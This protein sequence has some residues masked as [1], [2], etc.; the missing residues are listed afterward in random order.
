MLDKAMRLCEAPFG[1]MRHFDGEVFRAMAARDASGA[2]A[3]LGRQA[4]PIA[5]DPGSASERLVLGDKVVHIPDVVDTEAYRSGVPSRLRFVEMT[6][7]RTALWVALRKNDV[8]LGDLALYRKEVR[9]FT[10]KQIAL[11]ENFAAQAVIAM[12]N[13]RLLTET[14]EALEQQT[15]TA[16]VLQV[17][18]SSPGDR[19]PVF[20]VILEKARILCGAAQGSLSLYD[21]ERFRAVAIISQS[22]DVVD[23]M[24]QG[25]LPSDYPWLKPLLD[26]ARLVHV[27]DLVELG[28]PFGARTGLFVPLRKDGAL[29]GLISAIRLEVRPFSDKEIA[30]LENFAAQAVIAMENARLLTET[31][32]ALEQQTA[33]AEVLQVINSSPG[34]LAP[35]FDAMLEKAMRLCETPFG[36]FLRYDGG[37]YSLAAAK[38]LFPEFLNYLAHMDQPV[39]GDSNA[40]VLEGE[41]YVHVVDLKDTDTYRSGSPLRRANVDLGGFRSGLTVPLRKDDR[42]LGTFCIGRQEVRPFSEK[43]IALARNFAAQAVIAMENARLLGEL[44]QRTEEVAELNRGLEAH[45]AEQVDELGRIGRLKRFLAP[46]LAELIV[47]HG[48]EKILES[49]RR[50][51]VVVFCDLRG[52]TAFTETAEPEEVLDF[53]REYHGALGPLVSQF[54]GHARPVLRRRDHGVLQRSGALPRPCRARGQDGDG[55]ARRGG[56][57][58][59]HVATARARTRLW[60]WHRA[61]L[62]DPRADRLCR[63]VGLHRNWHR[64]QCRRPAVCRGQG[65]TDI[66]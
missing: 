56:Q 49:H 8:L 59:C 2:V 24:R 45:V 62:C 66:A 9:P 30:L 64:L 42:V 15:A 38:G 1:A 60:C 54:R 21:G 25:V 23:R 3:V 18:N 6:G 39:A 29:V 40:R 48:D 61:G 11:L 4:E 26:G 51:I 13:A 7:A 28:H 20:E 50:D 43:Q 31:R 5:P 55:D 16:E 27:P 57:I 53:L 14:R 22:Q 65:R 63:A 46:Q 33:T 19:T 52:Y 34:D 35:V 10:D 36:Y 37:T 32:E 41:A 12:E 47:S 44:R 58:D 17:I